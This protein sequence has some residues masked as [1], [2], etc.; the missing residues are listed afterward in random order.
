MKKCPYCGQE[1]PDEYSVCTIDENVLESI[2]PKQSL[3]AS[4]PA[5]GNPGGDDK[6][7]EDYEFLEQYPSIFEAKDLLARLERNR[8]RFQLE[9]VDKGE[10]FIGP[11]LWH[12]ARI[13]RVTALNVYVH[14][15]DR[16]MLKLI[17]NQPFDPT[18]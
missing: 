12:A 9:I 4:K 1:Y 18:P 7:G 10:R 6:I 16:N 14:K 3:Q 11:G 8:V 2:N 13:E 17:A 15:D 5:A